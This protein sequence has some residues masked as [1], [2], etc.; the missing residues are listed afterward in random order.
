MKFNLILFLLNLF[1]ISFRNVNG[2]LVTEDKNNTEVD[3]CEKIVKLF[4]VSNKFGRIGITNYHEGAGINY[5]FLT[6]SDSP[7][8]IFNKCTKQLYIL[9]N[10]NYKQFLNENNGLV[11]LTV[12]GPRGEFYY[13]IN[14]GVKYL[15][16]NGDKNDWRACK[17]T[18]DPYNYSKN[19]YQLSYLSNKT[20]TCESISVEIDY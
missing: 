1:V 11:Q 4:A 14:D 15:T 12:A 9:L 6:G 16:L 10:E 3:A 2:N 7:E 8:Y 18:N 5:L 20:S 17:N 13:E 19:L